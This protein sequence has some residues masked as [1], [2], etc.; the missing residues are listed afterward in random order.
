[1]CSRPLFPQVSKATSPRISWYPRPQLIRK[2]P[3][4]RLD[5][6]VTIAA[7]RVLE[8]QGRDHRKLSGGGRSGTFASHQQKISFQPNPPELRV[9]F[10]HFP[11]KVYPLLGGWLLCFL[12]FVCSVLEA[13]TL[14]E[15]VGVFFFCFV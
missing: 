10:F 9:L 5:L 2:C 3:A 14:R 1:M 8:W 6:R 12:V 4:G 11:T 13:K 7:R 15:R